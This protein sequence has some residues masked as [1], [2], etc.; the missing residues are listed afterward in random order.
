MTGIDELQA[1][2]RALYGREAR[3]FSAPGRVNLI[4]EHTDY[5]DG[6]VLPMAIDRRTFVA[7]APRDDRSIQAV[8]TGFED[9]VRFEPGPD[10][11]P[12]SDWANHVRGVAAGLRREPFEWRGADLLIAS[13]VPLG[14]GLS[15]SAA[16]EMAV[17]F[18]LLTLAG[19]PVD[20]VR[21]ALIAQ[22]AEHEF[23][24]TQC[25]I[26][27]Q[28]IAGL[29]IQD[30]ALLID[31]RSLEYRTVPVGSGEHRVVVCNTMIKHDLAS[32]EYNRRRADCEEGVRLLAAHLPGIR[33]LRDVSRSQFD[34]YADGLPEIV[35]RRCRHV[36]EENART[37]EAVEALEQGDLRLFGRLMFASHESL[38]RDYEVSCP[39]LDLMVE[40]ASRVEGV[41]GARMTGGGFGGST[42]NLVAADQIDHF[43]ATISREYQR[44][45]G[46]EPD[47][48]VCR[49][50]QGVRA[51]I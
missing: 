9:Q 42:V 10:L 48:Y 32:S 33:A 44:E 22:R 50:S 25:G 6:F 35:R 23:A 1:R 27:D 21:L 47:C 36:I 11:R 24:G 15:S 31:C 2:F 14:A 43:V 5:N 16:L 45:T 28:Y 51:E 29:G 19:Q 26:M 20:P 39:E 34:Q 8:S 38:R 46:I 7:A 18:A 49:A 12:G 30:H 40:T 37:L 3:I 41:L 13:D 17:G 4:G